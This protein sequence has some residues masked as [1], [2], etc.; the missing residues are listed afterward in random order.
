MGLLA[1][2]TRTPLRQHTSCSH[3][4]KKFNGLQCGEE[5]YVCYKDF[6]LIVSKANIHSYLIW[7]VIA[8][9]RNTY[10]KI[11]LFLFNFECNNLA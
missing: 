11:E 8:W 4:R 9:L 3:Q 5:P 2:W 1:V 10:E 7:N 6:E